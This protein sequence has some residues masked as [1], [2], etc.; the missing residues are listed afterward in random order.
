M[1]TWTAAQFSKSHF[2]G[3]D[4]AHRKDLSNTWNNDKVSKYAWML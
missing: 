2:H 4:Q 3:T 1:A